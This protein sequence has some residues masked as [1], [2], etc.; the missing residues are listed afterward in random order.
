MVKAFFDE[1]VL[2][3]IYLQVYQQALSFAV[4]TLCF[5]LKTCNN[6]SFLEPGIGIWA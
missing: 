1:L 6:S 5:T 4:M 2:S 3:K